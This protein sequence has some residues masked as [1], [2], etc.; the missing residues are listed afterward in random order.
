MYFRYD[1]DN[2]EI[3]GLLNMDDEFSEYS[4]Y[5]FLE[6]FVPGLRY[7]YKTNAYRKLEVFTKEVIENFMERKFREEEKSF[8]RGTS[9]E[10]ILGEFKMSFFFISQ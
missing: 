4:K 3:Q 1:F 5:G 6:D 10:Q 2:K 8:D 9:Q 7:V